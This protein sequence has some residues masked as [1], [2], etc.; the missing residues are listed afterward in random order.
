[1]SS[2]IQNP[3][4]NAHKTGSGAVGHVS[5]TGSEVKKDAGTQQ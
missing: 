4:Y 5:R 2:E 3:E 1:M